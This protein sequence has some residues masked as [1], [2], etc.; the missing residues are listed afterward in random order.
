MNGTVLE[1]LMAAISASAQN[2]PPSV[3]AGL[4]QGVGSL[5]G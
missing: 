1:P 3:V 2:V 5:L 4:A